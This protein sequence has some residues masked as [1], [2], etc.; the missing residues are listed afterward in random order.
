MT[1]C[2]TGSPSHA[3]RAIKLRQLAPTEMKDAAGPLHDGVVQLQ[4]FLDRHLT[5]EE[6]LN[7]PIL[8]HH[9]LRGV[10]PQRMD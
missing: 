1:R 3:N 5:D 8:L 2:W 9:K 6:G 10:G 4:G 7:I